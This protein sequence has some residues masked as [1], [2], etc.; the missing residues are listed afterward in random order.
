MGSAENV[1][2]HEMA[3]P[4]LCSQIGYFRVQGLHVANVD[5]QPPSIVCAV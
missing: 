5:G 2:H 1:V 3:F 4:E